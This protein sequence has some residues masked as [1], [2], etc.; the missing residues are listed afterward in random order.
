MHETPTRCRTHGHVSPAARQYTNLLFY[1]KTQTTTAIRHR[2]KEA[3][4]Y[5]CDMNAEMF[6]L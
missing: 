5:L 3:G 1:L 2:Q 6:N 4:L